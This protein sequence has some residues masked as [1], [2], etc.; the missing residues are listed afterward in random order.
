MSI[1]K[2][3]SIALIGVS[4]GYFLG[5]NMAKETYK[6]DD[7]K[8]LDPSFKETEDDDDWD[9]DWDDDVDADLDCPPVNNEMAEAAEEDDPAEES[10]TEGNDQEPVKK[11]KHE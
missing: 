4:A 8:N 3:L 10:T 7:G 1:A 2:T 6:A 9:D 5:W 11:E